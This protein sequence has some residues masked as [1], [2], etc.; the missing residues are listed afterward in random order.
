M[1]IT[2]KLILFFGVGISCIYIALVSF[3]ALS[4]IKI[5]DYEAVKDANV[6]VSFISDHIDNYT[7]NL[8]DVLEGV[9]IGADIAINNPENIENIITEFLTDD[10]NESVM[11]SAFAYNPEIKKW[12]PYQWFENG[13]LQKTDLTNKYDY[14]KQKWFIDATHLHKPHWTKAYQEFNDIRII[15]CTLPVYHNDRFI[16]VLTADINLDWLKKYI[17]RWKGKAGAILVIDKKSEKPVFETGLP[18]HFSLEL[19]NE[20]HRARE[21]GNENTEKNSYTFYNKET[22]ENIF[23]AFTDFQKLDWIVYVAFYEKVVRAQVYSMIAESILLLIVGILLIITLIVLIS[24]TITRPL[25]TLSLAATEVGKGN[26][27]NEIPKHHSGD[28]IGN[29]S[30]AFSSMQQNLLEHIHNLKETTARQQKMES[31]L[32]V[33]QQIQMAMLPNAARFEANHS[34]IDLWALQ[35]PARIVGGDLYD[36]F[37]LNEQHLFF[38]IGDVADKGIPAALFMSRTISSLRIFARQNLSPAEIVNNL[39][40]HLAANNSMQLFVTLF[41]GILNTT[42]GE[43]TYINAGHNPPFIISNDKRDI[44]K[45]VTQIQP[46]VGIVEKIQYRNDTCTLQPGER[47]FLY[48]DGLTESVNDEGAAFGEKNLIRCLQHSNYTTSKEFV[49][50]VQHCLFTFIGNQQEPFDDLSVLV[51]G[52][53]LSNKFISL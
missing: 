51:I 6:L 20:L 18:E 10:N 13:E 21:Q 30:D 46:A 43:L 26:F 28:E 31:E 2:T 27:F 35:K 23:V 8:E 11:G 3:L 25:R 7:E 47:L 9:T 49:C 34:G 29:L 45:L 15:S 19:I 40:G 36:F 33:A 41:C 37:M 48:T 38:A 17:N 22:K 5:T 4:F 52:R 50:N 39:N 32:Q 53:L 44:K 14:W 42:T 24:R 12:A 1:K 16:G